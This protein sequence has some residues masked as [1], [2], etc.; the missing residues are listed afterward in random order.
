MTPL[1]STLFLFSVLVPTKLWYAPGQMVP[2]DVKAD[3][4][5]TLVLTD[6]AGHK[7]DAKVDTKIDSPKQA[8]LT[9]MYPGLPIG[10]YLLSAVP[11][12]GAEANTF[13]GTPLVVEVRG[14]KRPGM[15][16]G[17]LVTH[18]EPL[19]YAVMDTDQGPMTMAFYY[20]VAPNT[21]SNFLSLADEGYF[22][23]IAFHR[24]IPGFVLQ[25]GDPLS[26]DPARAGTGGPGYTINAEFSNRPHVRGVLSMARQ[27][28]PEERGGNAPRYEWANSASSQFF[29]CLDYS[30]TKALDGKYTVFGQVTD[31]DDTMTKLAAVPTGP[32]DRPMSPPVIKKVT[33]KPVT[34]GNNP[35]AKL[36]QGK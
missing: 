24:I 7:I 13:V 8:D 32:N 16:A 18:V 4:P 25:A 28:D 6:F 14:D 30:R 31:G 34:P 33:V 5:V 17:P 19:R 15:P 9:Q 26:L 27:G 1:M 12:R 36:L 35:Y 21:V 29:I 11:Q 22:D 2:I 10:T 3:A 23:G 20:D